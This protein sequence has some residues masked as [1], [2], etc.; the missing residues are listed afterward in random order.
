MENGWKQKWV[1]ALRSG[2]YIQG[3]GALR[4]GRTHCCLGVLCD[5]IAPQ[6]WKS[7][8]D[9]L[10][11]H[12]N[13][14]RLYGKW[15]GVPSPRICDIAGLTFDDVLR[16]TRLNDQGASFAEIADHVEVNL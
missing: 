4:E 5:V 1:A 10:W 3:Y 16:L 15:F 13:P 8:E 9:H 2:L 12:D 14:R 6:R 7:H 11:S